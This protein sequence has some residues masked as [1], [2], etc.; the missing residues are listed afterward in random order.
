[1]PI[2]VWTIQKELKNQKA[3]KLNSSSPLRRETAAAG[4][5][6]HAAATPKGR[7][8]YHSQDIP[9]ILDFNPNFFSLSHSSRPCRAY[10][11]ALQGKSHRRSRGSG[12][13]VRVVKYWNKLPASAV[14]APAVKCQ[15]GFGGSL[16]SSLS[17]L[18][19]LP[20]HQFAY[21]PI[22]T[23]PHPLTFPI[24]TQVP[25]LS[26]WFLQVRFGLHLT[27]INHNNKQGSIYGMQ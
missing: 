18:T 20:F 6:F 10:Y 2:T 19:E 3:S 1:M 27:I 13:S 4:P 23:A 5:S 15:E 17:P 25:V 26:M 21:P 7:P 16:N 11:K 9:G 8:D 22:P 12:F 14:T 24:S